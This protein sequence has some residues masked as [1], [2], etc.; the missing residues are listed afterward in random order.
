MKKLSAFFSPAKEEKNGYLGKAT[1]IV[2]DAI[3][4]KGVS[5]FRSKDD[6]I[7]IRFPQF[8][9]GTEGRKLSYVTYSTDEVYAAMCSVVAQAME[10]ENHFA[11]QPGTYLK[12]QPGERLEVHGKPVQEQYAD[13]RFTVDVAGMV[14]LHGL[15]TNRQSYEKDGK[16]GQYTLVKLPTI[17]TYEVDG[18][19]RY[20]KAF[21]GR[22][23]TGTL[24]DGT[25]YSI[26]YGD[27][28]QGL[29][30]AE[31]KNVLNLDRKPPLSETINNA[32]AGKSAPIGND[33]GA[34]EPE[35]G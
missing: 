22:I 30:L 17:S 32:E 2:A 11:F 14:T 31:R 12:N 26:D 35:R 19:K 23:R 9:V 20:Q 13:A 1:I 34:K 5:V 16:Q 6:A 28:L 25:E 27:L 4:L 10:N 7:N 8:E 15:S 3:D 21:E 18:E 29:I 33:K 24:E